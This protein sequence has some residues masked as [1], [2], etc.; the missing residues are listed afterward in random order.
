MFVDVRKERNELWNSGRYDEQVKN[1]DFLKTADFF[2][3]KAIQLSGLAKKG[4][5]I[6]FSS[7]IG[8]C[9]IEIERASN[10]FITLVDSHREGLV[11]RTRIGSIADSI[12]DLEYPCKPEIVYTR[13]G[14]FGGKHGKPLHLFFADK[15]FK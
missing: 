15:D 10:H 13:K 8:G 3:T 1:L 6:R 14:V 11:S 2:T 9:W 7:N 4:N 5:W 12:K